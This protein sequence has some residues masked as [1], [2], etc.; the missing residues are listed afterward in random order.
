MRA[1]AEASQPGPAVTTLRGVSCAVLGGG[2]FLG[3]NLCRSLTAC[4]ARVRAFGRRCP[5]PSELDGVEWHQ[6][7]FS[8]QTALTTAIE[9][10]EIVFHLIH[11]NTPQSANLD[12]P[13]DVLQN[14]IPSIA[15]LEISRKL[16]VKRIVF[17]SSGG[18]I[19]GPTTELPTPETAPT[20]PISAYG[21]SKLAIEKYLALY[22]HLHGL[23]FRVL[24]VANAFGTYQLPTRNQG[25][26]AALIAGALRDREA[27][28]WGD[29]SIVRDYIF[30]DDVIDALHRAAVDQSNHRI[31]N[32]GSGEGRSIRQVIASIE[33]HFGKQLRI[34]ESGSR[35]I[36]VPISL[37]ATTRAK[38]T[39]AWQ[40]NT[41]FEVGLAAT[42]EWW[43]R[44]Q[45]ALAATR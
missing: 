3:L 45:H 30:V 27:E 1:D 43:R 17:V 18:T 24:R 32:I 37:L 35:A 5:F 9:S 11:T 7:D 42:I 29:G 41:P 12:V 4:G 10:S 31:F 16:A 22:E 21:V 33:A 6:G 38:E 28:I 8:D 34:K 40:P 44:S 2:G 14:V 36:D 15:L 13:R 26:V 20:N 39:L 19:Y 23:S 25:I